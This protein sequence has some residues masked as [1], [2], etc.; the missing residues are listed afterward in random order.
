MAS[1]KAKTIDVYDLEDFFPNL[2]DDW[3]EGYDG[4]IEFPVVCSDGLSTL[5]E[6]EILLEDF[7]FAGLSEE[8]DGDEWDDFCEFAEN[9]P[10]ALIRL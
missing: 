3:R 2:G 4:E 6:A 10:D 7:K 1:I 5:V 8:L 9:S